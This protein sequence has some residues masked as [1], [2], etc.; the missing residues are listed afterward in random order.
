MN[1]SELVFEFIKQYPPLGNKLQFN[2][3]LNKAN[4][5]SVYSISSDEVI[6]EYTGGLKKKQFTFGIS[7]I[8][9]FDKDNLS[10][11]NLDSFYD[12]ELFKEW[13]QDQNKAKNF[14]QIGDVLN[15][16]ATEIDYVG[17]DGV[18]LAK[19]AFTV[20]IQYLEQEEK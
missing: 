19:Y 7:G 8:K 9:K 18:N 2:A 6:K 4:T 13:V 11:L 20:S 15:M 16:K 10:D 12:F 5:Y 3:L 1:K 17:N 14:P